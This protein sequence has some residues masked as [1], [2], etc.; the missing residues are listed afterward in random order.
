M[1]NEKTVMKQ[2]IE[3]LKEIKVEQKEDGY[4]LSVK[5]GAVR[6]NDGMATLINAF[7]GWQER[8]DIALLAA[9]KQKPEAPESFV[10]FPCPT[11][12][13]ERFKTERRMNGDSWCRYGHKHPTKDFMRPAIKPE[14]D[15]LIAH[16]THIA[17]MRAERIK[18]LE[19]ELSATR[20][21][22]ISKDALL[23][24]ANKKRY[25][26]GSELVAERTKKSELL[27]ALVDVRD[28]VKE[29][30]PDMWRRVDEAIAKAEGGN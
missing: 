22:L 9:E 3:A 15:G 29:D 23:S 24:E 30:S 1:N 26:L 21:A 12:G 13:A 8:R 25:V 4:W 2:L 6:L 7:M 19:A 17:D 16:I 14:A 20:A 18:A 11:C 5:Y 28:N 27:A 10:T